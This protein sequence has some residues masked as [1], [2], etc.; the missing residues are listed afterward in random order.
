MPYF[1][2]IPLSRL[3]VLEVEL[4]ELITQTKGLR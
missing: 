4:E 2:T 1:E 3:P